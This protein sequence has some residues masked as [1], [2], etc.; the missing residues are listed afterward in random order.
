M[1]LSPT[2]IEALLKK[3]LS[4]GLPKEATDSKY[5]RPIQIGPLKWAEKSEPCTSRGCTSPTLIRILGAAKCTTHALNDLN[6]LIIEKEYDPE[7]LAQCT[8]KAGYYSKMNIHTFDCPVFKLED[9]PTDLL[10]D[11]L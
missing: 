10:D 9:A 5:P 2:E 6:F 3:E 8:C 4:R 7:W 1:A 11:L